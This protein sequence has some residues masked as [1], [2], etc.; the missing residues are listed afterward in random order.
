MGNLFK[1]SW[2]IIEKNVGFFIN[3]ER[4]I[5]QNRT[6]FSVLIELFLNKLVVWFLI[7]QIY[8]IY[9]QKKFY[10]YNRSVCKTLDKTLTKRHWLNLIYYQHTE[11]IKRQ[12]FVMKDL[13]PASEFLYVV[14][15]NDSE[16]VWKFCVFY[17]NQIQIPN[18]WIQTFNTVTK[19][20]S[21]FL[22]HIFFVIK[23]T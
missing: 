16:S 11:K 1:N 20:S 2:K 23:T 17:S 8:R 19:F 13:G 14:I 5:L 15:E 4:F 6:G 3:F 7:H 21:F 18:N 22:F 12:D 10:L 9:F